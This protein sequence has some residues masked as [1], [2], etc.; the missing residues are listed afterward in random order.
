[1]QTVRR[2]PPTAS[3]PAEC[4]RIIPE[5]GCAD[6]VRSG[7]FF[8]AVAGSVLFVYSV[9]LLVR[10]ILS[11]FVREGDSPFSSL[12]ILITEPLILP[13]R[14]LCDRFGWFQ[15]VPMDVPFLL[16][17]LFVSLLTTLLR[18]LV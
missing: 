13:V 2:I 8:H 12:L 6:S 1:M 4:R 17:A 5:G 16:T 3:N 9:A 18:A 7:L 14:H 10:A 11:W 15:G